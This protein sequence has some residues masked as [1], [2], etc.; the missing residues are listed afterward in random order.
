MQTHGIRLIDN[1]PISENTRVLRFEKI[2][3]SG[4]SF[5]PGEFVSL[6][7]PG[8]NGEIIK[9][10]YSIATLTDTPE[11]AAVLEVVASFVEN[12]R[13]THWFWHTD[14]GAEIEFA[15]P[16]GQLVM[17]TEKPGRL[18]LIATGTGVAP[19]RSMLTQM[20]PWLEQSLP[21][22]VLFGVRH[23]NEAFY[24]E[25]FRAQARAFPSFSFTL[26]VSRESSR[27][28]DEYHG[29]VTGRLAELEPNAASDLVYLCGN[30][31]MVDEIFA[32]LKEKGFGVRSVRREKYV[33]A[34]N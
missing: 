9:R 27:A 11:N 29:R 21:I 25:D 30:P 20:K 15:G 3:G 17:P 22:H 24:L 8:S 26:C 19:Y 33:F 5:R 28:A 31:A 12:G 6:H 4:F 16:H 1:Q 14:T 34:R 23:R 10:S 18:I 32:E 7:I 13:A 2:D